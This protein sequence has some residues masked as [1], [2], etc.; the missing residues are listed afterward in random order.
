[1][2][3]ALHHFNLR[4][5]FKLPAPFNRV[6]FRHADLFLYGLLGVLDEVGQARN[7]I[8]GLKELTGIDSSVAEESIT[9]TQPFLQRQ[10]LGGGERVLA[11]V[12]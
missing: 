4:K 12:S 8:E 6:S 9:Q 11:H 5:V 10:A 7:V 3:T 2:F 1:M